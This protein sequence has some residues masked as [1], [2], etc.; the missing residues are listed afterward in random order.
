MGRGLIL[1]ALTGSIA[2]SYEILWA[3][4]Y[5]FVSGAASN[6]FGILLAS[7]LFGLGLGALVAGI[8]CRNVEGHSPELNRKLGSFVLFANL[9][10]YI[11]APA[12]SWIVLFIP[13]LWT[14]PLIVL[15]AGLLG[16]AFPLISH[17][18]IPADA[19]AGLRLSF[20][21]LANIAGSSIGSLLTGFVLLDYFSFST[22]SV[23]LVIAGI[24][25][26]TLISEYR[27]PDNT[28]AT[29]P[30]RGSDF[31][32]YGVLLAVLL[33]ILLSKGKLF[34]GMYERLQW[35]KDMFAKGLDYR[36]ARLYESKSGVIA[37]GPDG[38][39][40]GG[41]MYDGFLDY[42]LKLG[43]WLLRPY[44]LSLFHPHPRRVLIVGVSGGAWTAVVNGHPQVE[45]I[46]AVEINKHYRQVMEDEPKM[47]HLLTSPKLNLVFD[48][49][50]RW[51][52]RNPEEHFDAVVMNTTYHFRTYVSN[53]LSRE[54][55]TLVSSHL[56]PGGVF[57]FNTTDSK[58]AMRTA[59]EVFP[60]CMMIL[61][62]TICSKEPLEFNAKRWLSVLDS[63]RINGEQILSGEEGRKTRAWLET[64]TTEIDQKDA[65]YEREGFRSQKRMLEDCSGARIVTDDNMATEYGD[66]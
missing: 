56:S 16:A 12:A 47:R 10:G 19:R 59:L 37:I 65:L 66:H 14:L 13:Y 36:F 35:K 9:F 15:S 43:G 26:A 29:V 33:V 55:M 38:S 46:T 17:I 24:L 2:L 1:S 41:G 8:I 63:Y 21:Y 7:Y 50:R 11:I 25:L 40:H 42:R 34:D 44:S 52:N 57:L 22:I 4:F 6:S 39:V 3:R 49:G 61:N 23:I 31:R 45:S 54:Y 51:L 58:E 5:S 32:R 48:D 28:K 20:V 64:L 60:H 30:A 18:T 53:L 27:D 62:A